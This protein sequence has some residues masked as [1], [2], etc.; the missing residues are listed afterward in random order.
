MVCVVCGVVWCV[1]VCVCVCMC[2]HV[3]ECLHAHTSA[4]GYKKK[5]VLCVCMHECVCT[6]YTWTYLN[7]IKLPTKVLDGPLSCGA[8]AVQF[9]QLSSH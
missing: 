3:Q 4:H 2:V 6:L 9:F 7:L 5:R 8:L 1:C